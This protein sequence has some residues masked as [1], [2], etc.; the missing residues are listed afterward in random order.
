MY[1]RRQP[2]MK[3][4]V[5]T[6]CCDNR[7]NKTGSSYQFSLQI[8]CCIDVIIYYKKLISRRTSLIGK[9][10]NWYFQNIIYLR[11]FHNIKE[12]KQNQT[13]ENII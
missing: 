5:T 9:N 13:P 2:D 11:N 7:V 6:K 10:I 3:K 4:E 8:C 1:K 12:I